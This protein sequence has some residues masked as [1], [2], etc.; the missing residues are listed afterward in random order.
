MGK[1]TMRA[2][3]AYSRSEGGE[4]RVR[5]MEVTV[6]GDSARDAAMGMLAFHALAEVAR[7]LSPVEDSPPSQPALVPAKGKRPRRRT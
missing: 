3:H 2:V 6:E 4:T 7:A 1:V 5:T